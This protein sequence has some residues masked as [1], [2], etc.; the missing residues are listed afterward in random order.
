MVSSGREGTATEGEGE[1]RRGGGW[2]AGVVGGMVLFSVTNKPF[3]H[4]SQILYY[5]G[6]A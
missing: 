3:P 4:R 2:G 5:V 1:A 6:R